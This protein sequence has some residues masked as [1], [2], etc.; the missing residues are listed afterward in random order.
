M[1]GATRR[2]VIAA[3]L[4]EY[5]LMGLVSAAIAGVIGTIAAYLIMTEVLR[6]PF[7][8]IPEAVASTT[9]VALVIT[10]CL[11]LIGT[12]RALGHKAAPLLRN[13]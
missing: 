12:W 10:L 5:G 4:I 11:G 6:G 3:F 9:V 8:F 1:L 2:N 13:D 7:I